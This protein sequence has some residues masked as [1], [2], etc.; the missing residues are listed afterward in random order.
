MLW[1][2]EEMIGECRLPLANVVLQDNIAEQWKWRLDISG[3]YSVRSAYDMLTSDNSNLVNEVSDL[4]W[5]KHVPLKVSILA[6]RLLRNRL[7]TQANLVAR[8][9]L[10]QDAN[11]CV[12]G[13]G[14][15]ETIQHLFV[16]CP[17]YSALW[18]QV[19]AWIGVS[20]ADP[21]E[22]SDHFFSSLFL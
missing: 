2:W 22:E 5:H 10:A 13:C 20:G 6:W 7:P 14:E 16:S 12:A 1:D 8:G 9:M 21:I 3:T 15:V 4:I 17:I 19:R 11:L 18:H